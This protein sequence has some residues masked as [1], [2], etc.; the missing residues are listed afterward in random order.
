M[1]GQMSIYNNINEIVE[2][3]SKDL[4]LNFNVKLSLKTLEKAYQT[5]GFPKDPRRGDAWRS[6][7]EQPR[8]DLV[9]GLNE[10]LEAMILKGLVT[11]IKTVPLNHLSDYEREILKKFKEQLLKPYRELKFRSWAWTRTEEAFQIADALIKFNQMN[12]AKFDWTKVEKLKNSLE[13]YQLFKSDQSLKNFKKLLKEISDFEESNPQFALKYFEENIDEETTIK[14][15]EKRKIIKTIKHVAATVFSKFL[16]FE[17]EP[18]EKVLYFQIKTPNVQIW[19]AIR[20]SKENEIVLAV[21]D[22]Q[23]A[24]KNLISFNPGE[25]PE[26]ISFWPNDESSDKW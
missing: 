22:V 15:G 19:N 5:N 20:F 18:L 4:L 24:E 10:A 7:Y 26:T 1:K 11:A 23:I 2:D 3:K 14:K 17:F 8:K 12:D 13:L 25:G 16:D 21:D 9:Q 6:S